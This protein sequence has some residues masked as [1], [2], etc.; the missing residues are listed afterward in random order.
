MVVMD[1]YK[2]G[3]CPQHESALFVAIRVTGAKILNFGGSDYVIFHKPCEYQNKQNNTTTGAQAKNPMY[4]HVPFSPK[5]YNVYV[6]LL[7]ESFY[8]KLESTS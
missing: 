3:G 7:W 1:T 8:K 2:G 4:V 5:H 6:V